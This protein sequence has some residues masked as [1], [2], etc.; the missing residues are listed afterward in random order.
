MGYSYSWWECTIRE[1]QLIKNFK[2]RSKRRGVKFWEL[3]GVGRGG[4]AVITWN[5]SVELRLGNTWF[6]CNVTA[7]MLIVKNKRVSLCWEIK[8]YQE[9]S[10][11]RN[12][13]VLTTNMATYCVIANQLHIH[14]FNN[15]LFF[16]QKLLSFMQFLPLLSLV[17]GTQL[18]KLCG[19]YGVF[20]GV[21]SRNFAQICATRVLCLPVIFLWK[22][23]K[24][25]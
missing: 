25:G 19:H 10:A 15:G 6:P 13:I 17:M 16:I 3:A 4:G 18:F 2:R 23:G 1:I 21:Q 5:T 11:K 22:Q 14:L 24:G 12:C 9:N 20:L 7:V 8:Y